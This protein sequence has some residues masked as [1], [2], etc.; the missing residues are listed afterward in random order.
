MT[1]LTPARRYR[2]ISSL[3]VGWASVTWIPALYEFRSSCRAWITFKIHA[4]FEL[5]VFGIVRDAASS[6]HSS[7]GVHQSPEIRRRSSGALDRFRFRGAINIG[8]LMLR[9]P[10]ES[11]ARADGRVDDDIPSTA[12]TTLS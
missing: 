10:S 6:A 5:D 8:Q 12:H 11:W 2:S 7:G 4:T 3:M 1:P 9:L